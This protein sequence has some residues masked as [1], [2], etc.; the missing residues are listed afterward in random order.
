MIILSWEK[1]TSTTKKGDLVQQITFSLSKVKCVDCN[2]IYINSDI[3]MSTKK[4]GD[5]VQENTCFVPFPK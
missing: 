1:F 3:F 4:K 5:M 2:L